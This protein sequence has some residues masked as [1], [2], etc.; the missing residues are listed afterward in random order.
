MYTNAA[1]TT[2][3]AHVEKQTA[4]IGIGLAQEKSPGGGRTIVKDIEG[5]SSTRLLDIDLTPEQL[6]ELDRPVVDFT[7]ES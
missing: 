6:A 5:E 3:N 2:I 1:S 7:V 4:V